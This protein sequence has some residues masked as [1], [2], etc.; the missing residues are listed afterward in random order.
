[1]KRNEYHFIIISFVILGLIIAPQYVY[2]GIKLGMFSPTSNDYPNNLSVGLDGYIGGDLQLGVDVLY[3]P[4]ITGSKYKYY[5]YSYPNGYG[6]AADVTEF[7]TDLSLIN[8]LVTTRYF[9]I[10][11]VYL[12]AGAGGFQTFRTHGHGKTSMGGEVDEP[13]GYALQGM[14][15]FSQRPTNEKEHFLFYGEVKYL[16]QKGQGTEETESGTDKDF[17]TFNGVNIA[18]GISF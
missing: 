5:N 9:F 14:I 4:N 8:C 2:A 11:N 10:K 12:G 1:M 17:N 6:S 13:W 3:V 7:T 15:G 16:Y 18:V